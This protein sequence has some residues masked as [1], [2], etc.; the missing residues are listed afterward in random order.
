MNPFVILQPDLAQNEAKLLHKI[1]LLA[2]MEVRPYVDFKMHLHNLFLQLVFTRHAHDRTVSFS[3][4]A[5]AA[6]IPQTQVSFFFQ[7]LISLQCGYNLLLGRSVGNES[8]IIWL[9]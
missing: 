2:L 9:S 6:Q 3:V 5:E 4:I 8:S 7:S 1:R